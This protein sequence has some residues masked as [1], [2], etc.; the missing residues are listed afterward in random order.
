MNSKIRI[1]MGAIEVEYEGSEAFLR[2]ELPAFLTAVSDLYAKS[3]AVAQQSLGEGQAAAQTPHGKQTPTLEM[4]TAS[5]ASKL[6]VSSGPQL[7]MAAAAHLRFVKGLEK[8]PRKQ[9]S[10]QMRSASSFFKESYVSNLS[11]L[12][13]TLMKENKLNEP[14][15]GVYALT[16]AAE[17]DLK[18]RLV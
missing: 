12:I 1:K 9:L 14:S 15:N 5:I 4:T 10:E 7:V 8:F 16:H 2:E 17:Q 13:K 3:G 6:G 18:A 11:P